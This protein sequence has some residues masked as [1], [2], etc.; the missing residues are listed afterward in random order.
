MY[1][2]S[3]YR[4]EAVQRQFEI[5]KF[6]LNDTR[7]E[8]TDDPEGKRRFRVPKLLSFEKEKPTFD[9]EGHAV[10][11]CEA[12]YLQDPTGPLA[13]QALYWAAGVNYYREDYENADRYYSTLVEQFPRS[14]LAP[15][16][17]ELAI[18]SKI[19]S[20]HGTDYD[21]RK[22]IEA[23]DLTD[24]ALRTYPE[25]ANK[26]N[27]LENTLVAIN[28]QQA[29]K[30]FNTAEFY[31]RTGHPGAAYFCYEI[32]RRRYGGTEWAE[33]AYSRMLE[34]RSKVEGAENSAEVNVDIKP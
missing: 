33:K 26:Q 28:N 13:A 14:P 34:L 4:A 21:G 18:Q 8:M 5:A 17:L 25:L 29:E 9:Q 20:T 6:W 19:H 31:R 16:A 12:I 30:D 2:S 23:R 10:A 27:M 3:Q 22:L 1:P 24:A 15:Y 32:V 7:A 11:A